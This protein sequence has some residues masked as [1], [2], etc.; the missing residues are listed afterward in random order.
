MAEYVE[1]RAEEMIK[2]LE[3]MEKLQLFDKSEIRQIIKKRKDFEYKLMRRTK[4]KE[5]FLRYI[6]YEMDVMKLVKIRKETLGINQNN[7]DYLVAR[8]IDNVF[9]GALHRFGDDIRLWLSYIKFCKRVHFYAS[10]SR[11]LVKMV[12][13]HS[14]KPQ[15]WKL[16]ARWE[17]EESNS[18]ESARQFLL[19]GLRFHPDSKLLYT[20]AFHLELAYV[21]KLRAELDQKKEKEA[22]AA[23]TDAPSTVSGDAQSAADTSKISTTQQFQD[24]AID[25]VLDGRLAEVIYESAVKKVNE[26][27]FIIGLLAVAKEFDF[28]NRLQMKIINDMLTRYPNDELTWDAMARRELQG[29]PYSTDD[30]SST[31]RE[32]SA[33]EQDAPDDGAT[34]TR[35]EHAGNKKLLESKG[36]SGKLCLKERIR[37]CVAVYDA[38]VKQL[39]TERMWSLYIETMQELAQEATPLPTFK[40][41]MLRNAYQGAHSA[42]RMQTKYYL[43]WVDM[44]QSAGKLKKLCGVLRVATERL[45][46]SAELWHLRLR[47]HLAR[48]EEDQAIAVFR[49]AVSH[50]GTREAAALPLWKVLLQYYQTKS[51]ARVEEV[52]QNAV[53]Q[54]DS[55]VAVAL[56]PLYLEW[57]VLVKGIVA[58]RKMYEK[59]SVQPPLCLEMHSKMAALECRVPE[60]NFKHV[61]RCYELACEQFGKNNTDVWMD[62]V[63]FEQKLGEA[64]NVSEIYWRALKNLDP[65][66][67]DAFISEFSL[68]KT[69]MAGQNAATSSVAL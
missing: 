43:M 22:S 52:F 24:E 8:R 16:A 56:K 57:L 46:L 36:L 68:V 25:E 49:D 30:A 11:M 32:R 15:M 14:D 4:C 67:T 12:Q 51:M 29:L 3:Q 59:L 58:A 44:L 21:K 65:K 37:R 63:K 42:G 13:V 62:Y 48:N 61:R 17:F 27:S 28:T 23:A 1:F 18:V 64:K 33:P 38:A 69:G 6:Q 2:E 40:R 34:E 9:K 35:D 41:K 10:V 26:V 31:E 47:L 66:H 50:L 19:R 39:P 45:P 5:D 20:E 7:I 53:S 55:P 60:V 54:Q